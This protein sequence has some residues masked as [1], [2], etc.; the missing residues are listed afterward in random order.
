MSL[1][2]SPFEPPHTPPPTRSKSPWLILLAGGLLLIP[3][4]CCGGFLALAGR[5]VSMALTERG[6]VQKVVNDYL[7]K[8]DDKDA[9]G[10]YALFSPTARKSI[11]QSKIQE[12]LEGQNYSVFSDFQSAIV[13]N[14]QIHS[15]PSRT[16]AKV[17]GTVTYDGGV[18]GTFSGVVGREGDAWMIDGMN[19]TVPPSKLTAPKSE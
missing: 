15:T 11:P 8:M 9:A 10:A 4:L 19:V 13:T 18:R 3:C 1:P 6:N 14:I 12:L 7:R 16:V 2:P 17:Q 5:G